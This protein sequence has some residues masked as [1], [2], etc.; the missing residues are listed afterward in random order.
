MFDARHELLRVM[1]ALM[2]SI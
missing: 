1:L 2:L